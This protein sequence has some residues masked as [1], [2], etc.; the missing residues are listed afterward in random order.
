MKGNVKESG[1]GKLERWKKTG[2]KGGISEILKEKEGIIKR[3]RH[4]K[5]KES[6]IR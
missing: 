3:K 6:R 2:K 1:R 4:K 5:G